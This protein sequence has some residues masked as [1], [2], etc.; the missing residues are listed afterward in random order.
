ME[1][2]TPNELSQILT[3]HPFTATRLAQTNIS[4]QVI[5]ALPIR[6]ASAGLM[7]LFVG[8]LAPGFEQLKTLKRQNDKRHAT[9][10]LLLPRLMSG[11][12]AV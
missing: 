11:G 10:D 3:L 12:I 5:R 8:S 9:R 6:F 7:T 1:L 4:Q 2:L